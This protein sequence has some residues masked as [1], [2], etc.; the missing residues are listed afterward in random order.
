MPKLTLR[1]L[2]YT[3]SILLFTWRRGTKVGTDEHGNEYYRGKP[4]KGL[5]RERRWVLYAGEPEASKVPA[6]WHAWL[7]HQPVPPPTELPPVQ[8]TWIKEHQPNATG[9]AL[10]YRPPGH[11]LEGGRRE[12]ATGDY[13][14]WTPPS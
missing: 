12:A 7:H 9:T 2:F 4:N 13:E 11:V 3:S 5:K 1:S 10:A 6:T 14:S 8:R